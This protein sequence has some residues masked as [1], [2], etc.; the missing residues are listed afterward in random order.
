MRGDCVQG[1]HRREV[2]DL[3]RPVPLSDDQVC[4]RICIGKGRLIGLLVL[5]LARHDV[6]RGGDRGGNGYQNI[7]LRTAF[8][9]G[10]IQSN[11]L[12]RPLSLLEEYFHRHSS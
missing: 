5:L 8:S 12:N 6:R 7:A 3:N 11:E 9:L 2:E 1:S 10:K 4:G